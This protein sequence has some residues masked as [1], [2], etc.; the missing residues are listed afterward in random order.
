MPCKNE[1]N[2]LTLSSQANWPVRATGHA[3][4]MRYAHLSIPLFKLDTIN[5]TN[6][7]I[8]VIHN[9]NET[10]CVHAIRIYTLDTLQTHTPL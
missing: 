2:G 7:S 9:Q 3:N 6:A 5:L 4:S 8:N 1:V 10:N